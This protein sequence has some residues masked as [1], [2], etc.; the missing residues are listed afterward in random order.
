MIFHYST[1]AR[2]SHRLL[3]VVIDV[4]QQA[5]QGLGTGAGLALAGAQRGEGGG[6]CLTASRA[7]TPLCLRGG[8]GACCSLLVETCW[9]V[10]GARV[11]AQDQGRAGVASTMRL[12]RTA[13]WARVPR[14]HS[15]QPTGHRPQVVQLYPGAAPSFLTDFLRPG[16]R[17]QT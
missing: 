14:A 17:P 11:R 1:R 15:P 12:G 10:A 8:S 7:H 16:T 5:I 2:A 3:V 9:R 13:H 4:A 6:G